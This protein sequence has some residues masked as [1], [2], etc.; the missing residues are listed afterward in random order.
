MMSELG[1]GTRGASLA[2]GA[3]LAASHKSKNRLFHNYPVHHIKDENARLFDETSTLHARHLEGINIEYDRIVSA[4]KNAY[5]QKEFPVIISG[6]HASAAGSIKGIKA[7]HPD[8]RLGV[9]W[10]DAHADLHSPYTTPSGNVHGMPLGI[11]LHEDNLEMAINQPS[12][13]TL[14]QWKIACG[15]HPHVKASDLVFFGVRDTEI[16]EDELILNRGI[17]NYTVEEFRRRGTKTCA[18]EALEYLSACDIIY[19]SFDVDS[20]DSAV[21]SGTG[22]PVIN[23]FSPVECEKMILYLLEDPRIACFELVEINPT[24]DTKGNMMA[25]TALKILNSVVKKITK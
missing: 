14:E 9:I 20:M 21:S 13:E 18:Q 11:A 5:A 4:L 15:E 19:I 16:P 17:R 7:A 25:E 3:L 1:A 23:G 6:S 22:T 2:F 10:I 12:K 24:L 8:K